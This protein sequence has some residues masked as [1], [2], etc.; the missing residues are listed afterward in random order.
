VYRSSTASTI[1]TPEQRAY[2]VTGFK[3]G[4]ADEYK[5]TSRPAF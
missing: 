2:W 1:F 5:A 3:S 4:F